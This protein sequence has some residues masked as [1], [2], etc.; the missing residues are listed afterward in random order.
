LSVAV[1]HHHHRYHKYLAMFI[2]QCVC[3][4]RKSKEQCKKLQNFEDLRSDDQ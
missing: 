3:C 2:L 1:D 4:T